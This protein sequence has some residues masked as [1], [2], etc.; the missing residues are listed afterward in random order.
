MKSNP[1]AR[2][3]ETRWRDLLIELFVIGRF[4]QSMLARPRVRLAEMLY[5]QPAHKPA[6][7]PSRICMASAC[8]ARITLLAIRKHV[9]DPFERRHR[10]LVRLLHTL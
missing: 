4:D 8:D 5:A 2:T 6:E 1:G 9:S 3:Q 10:L 7:L